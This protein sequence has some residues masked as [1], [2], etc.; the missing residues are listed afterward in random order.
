MVHLDDHCVH[1]FIYGLVVGPFMIALQSLCFPVDKLMDR[2]RPHTFALSPYRLN[3]LSLVDYVFVVIRYVT[4]PWSWTEIKERIIAV[5]YVLIFVELMQ[6]D[7][8]KSHSKLFNRISA[9]HND[10]KYIPMRFVRVST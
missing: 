5:N 8:Q 9:I 3:A 1:P 6:S 10:H 2:Y 4:S 7:V